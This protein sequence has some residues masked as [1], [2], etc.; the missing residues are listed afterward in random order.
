MPESTKYTRLDQVLRAGLLLLLSVA[1]A[2]KGPA[3]GI[4]GKGA[5][6]AALVQLRGWKTTERQLIPLGMQ[7][8]TKKAFWSGPDAQ[9]CTDRRWA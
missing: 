6:L 9:P 8:P 7:N 1:L 2:G 5:E 4:E 3:Q